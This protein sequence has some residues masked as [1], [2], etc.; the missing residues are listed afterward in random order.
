MQ[1]STEH[2]SITILIRESLKMTSA[3][4]ESPFAL[5][6]GE[7]T[8]IMFNIRL[9]WKFAHSR[10]RDCAMVEHWTPFPFLQSFCFTRSEWYLAWFEGMKHDKSRDSTNH[11]WKE[12]FGIPTRNWC[13]RQPIRRSHHTKGCMEETQ[14]NPRRK[15]TIVSMSRRI[16]RSSPIPT[17]MV[18]HG[19][20]GTRGVDSTRGADGMHIHG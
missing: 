10:S 2:P 18:I 20:D 7:L 1:H 11:C 6:F 4:R 3:K 9:Y 8:Q 12:E 14:H 5:S 15:A 17:G 16:G 19:K 13:G